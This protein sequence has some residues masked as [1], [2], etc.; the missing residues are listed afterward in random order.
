MNEND[1]AR[2]VVSTFESLEI[3]YFITGSMA[4]I[5]MGEPRYTND[6]DIVADIPPGKIGQLLAAFP[7]PEFYLSES[8]VREAVSQRFQ[9]NII[10]PRSGLKVD[11]ML[12]VEDAFDRTR[13]SRKVRL[14]VDAETV[15]WFSSAEDLILKKLVF[16]QLGGSEKHLRDVS[17][18][19]LVQGDRIDRTYLDQ[20][21]KK[22]GVTEELALVQRRLDE[23]QE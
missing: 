10:H 23:R 2:K 22:L 8:A 13:M 16:F 20:W 14:N 7:S 18:V 12:L 6:I 5:A 11:V 15:G 17:G 1:L 21:A 3:P 4:S 9:F 19:L